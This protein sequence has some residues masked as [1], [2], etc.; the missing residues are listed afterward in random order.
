MP[1]LPC[2]CPASLVAHERR[3]LQRGLKVPDDV[4]IP[5]RVGR[6]LSTWVI[7]VTSSGFVAL[8]VDQPSR[9]SSRSLD[10]SWERRK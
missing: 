7:V 5:A 8:S 10:E 6:S 4:Q 9:S 3:H 2:P 1:A